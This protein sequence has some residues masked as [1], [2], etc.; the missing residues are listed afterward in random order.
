M[1]KLQGHADIGRYHGREIQQQPVIFPADAQGAGLAHKIDLLSG[2]LVD[3][4]QHVGAGQGRMATERNFGG[5][6]EPADMPALPFTDHKGCFR[7]VVLGGDVL[8]QLV[9]QPAVEPIDHGRVAGKRAMAKGVDLEII[10][11]H[12]HHTHSICYR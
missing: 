8:H 7:Q 6:G 3:L 4:E 12:K 11:L 1:L 9:R 10:K 5:R 2:L